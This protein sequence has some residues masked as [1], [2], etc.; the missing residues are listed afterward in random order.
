[1]PDACYVE[2]VGD[3][4]DEFLGLVIV[5]QPEELSWAYDNDIVPGFAVEKISDVKD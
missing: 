5:K 3:L 1:M 2:V 4:Q